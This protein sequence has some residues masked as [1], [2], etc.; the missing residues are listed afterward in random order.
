[1]K[2]RIIHTK[3][4]QDSFVLSLDQKSRWVFL[5]LLTNNRVE[6]TGCYELPLQIAEI[7]LGLSK[8]EIIK[9]IKSLQPKILYIDGFIIIKN[10]KKYQDYSKGNLNQQSAYNKELELL[11]SNIKEAFLSDDIQ[12][13]GNQSATSCQLDINKK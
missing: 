4:Y 12:L 2:T 9:I 1:M 11:P 13:V 10:I 7:E 6:L 5:Y 3:F 8:A